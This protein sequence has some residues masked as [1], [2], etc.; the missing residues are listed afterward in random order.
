[1]DLKA[2]HEMNLDKAGFNLCPHADAPWLSSSN[3]A[4]KLHGGARAGLWIGLAAVALLVLALLGTATLI[5]AFGIR[6]GAPSGGGITES[7][8]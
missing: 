7:K 2:S 4:P 8:N 1:V 3:A 5:I 6:C